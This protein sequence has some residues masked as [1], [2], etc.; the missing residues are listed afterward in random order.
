MNRWPWWQ[1]YTQTNADAVKAL[2]ML[3]AIE[4]LTKDDCGAASI[5]FYEGRVIACASWTN[6]KAVTERAVGWG[7]RYEVL[8]RWLRTSRSR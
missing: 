8:M 2:R 4:E 6:W 5:T 7:M 1:K 3:D